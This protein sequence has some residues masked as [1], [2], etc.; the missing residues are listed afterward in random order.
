MASNFENEWKQW[1]AG[2]YGRPDSVYLT[3]AQGKAIA[4]MLL[5]HRRG[6]G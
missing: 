4:Y 1:E 5:R 6:G 2:Q 3:P